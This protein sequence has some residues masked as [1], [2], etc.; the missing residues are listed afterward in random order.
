VLEQSWRVGGASPAEITALEAFRADASLRAVRAS[1]PEIYDARHEPPRHA[2]VYF[3]G[4]D[5][6]VGALIKYSVLE[7]YG[8]SR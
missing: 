8:N 1:C 3:C 4:E 7:A 2:H 5:Q 6:E